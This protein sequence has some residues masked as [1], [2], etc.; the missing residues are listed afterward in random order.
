ML[1]S[2]LLVGA[3]SFVGGALR[4]L[5]S[6]LMKGCCGTSFPWAT[7]A[8]NIVGCFIIGV[9]YAVLTRCVSMS[10][11]LCLLL[12]TGFCGGFTTFSAFANEGFMMLQ[13]GSTGAFLVYAVTSV[14]AGVA[15][16][17]LGY[18]TVNQLC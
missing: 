11:A 3:G 16:V 2:I 13:G 12:A 7:L 10:H 6:L 1:K 14:L 18:W 8:V 9:V 5:V 17:A 4:Y 15:L